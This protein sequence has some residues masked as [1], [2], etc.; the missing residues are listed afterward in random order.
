MQVISAFICGFHLSTVSADQRYWASIDFDAN[1]T[2]E[3]YMTAIIIN[4]GYQGT[5]SIAARLTKTKIA[6]STQTI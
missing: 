3:M 6:T 5:F 2:P 4:G 1:L